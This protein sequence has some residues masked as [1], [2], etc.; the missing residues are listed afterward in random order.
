MKFRG[1]RC[2]GAAAQSRSGPAPSA[3]LPTLARL[4][5]PGGA[6]GGEAKPCPG[7]RLI[8]S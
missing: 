6:R 7:R 1:H 5:S 8:L 2:K 4:G 3:C